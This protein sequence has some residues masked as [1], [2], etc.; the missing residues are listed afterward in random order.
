MSDKEKEKLT[1]NS[2]GLASFVFTS[3]VILI[4]LAYDLY[5]RLSGQTMITDYCRAHPWAAWAI[6]AIIQFGVMG[7]A[8]H[9]M[10]PVNV[11]R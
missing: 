7:L 2:L 3:F 6:L 9:F 11:E 5:L 8:V 4:T 10:A 1:W